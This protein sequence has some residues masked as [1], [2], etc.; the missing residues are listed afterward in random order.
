MS[1]PAVECTVA[2]PQAAA[3]HAEAIA[4]YPQIAA[5]PVVSAPVSAYEAGYAQLPPDRFYQFKMWLQSPEGE[6]YLRW[7]EQ[8]RDFLQV[9]EPL[10]ARWSQGWIEAE[11][12]LLRPLH[13]YLDIYDQFTQQL[14]THAD[15]NPAAR[16]AQLYGT[17]DP[18]NPLPYAVLAQR[19]PERS[20]LQE[21]LA[22]YDDLWR[23]HMGVELATGWKTSWGSA[24]N[25]PYA[26]AA[27]IRQITAAV[28]SRLWSASELPAIPQIP[29]YQPPVT[30]L[31]ESMSGLQQQIIEASGGGTALPTH[32]LP[33]P[34]RP[35][36]YPSPMA[37]ANP[38]WSR[39]EFY[40]GRAVI[41]GGRAPWAEA[42][43]LEVALGHPGSAPSVC[44]QRFD[45]SVGW[46]G[47]GEISG[48]R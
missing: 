3:R 4:A 20:A 47:V 44:V 8:A 22:S 36:G 40:T 23:S 37:P 7:E 2:D 46:F 42:V 34:F 43:A 21:R 25:D 41:Y 28:T 35:E 10:N 16:H 14:I 30:G 38:R 33:E 29:T 32:S 9:V 39:S 6:N 18:M 1:Y 15:L 17:S 45:G 5:L 31:P 13:E 48:I 26:I 24:H 12:A 19:L 27:G 11:L